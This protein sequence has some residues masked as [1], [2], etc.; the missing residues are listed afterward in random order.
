[1]KHKKST[2]TGSEQGRCSEWKKNRFL[3]LMLVP[4]LIVL[5]FNNY[6]PM[7]GIV[8]A[9]EKINFK[10]FAFFGEWVGLSNLKA[11]FKSTY[12][13]VILKNTLLYNLAF[14][15]L[16]LVIALFFAISLN[17]LRS[18]YGR[19][20]YQTIMFLPYFMSWAVMTGIV[21]AFLNHTNGLMNSAVL[22]A[23]G[24]N[25]IKWYSSPKYWPFILTFI[26][27]WKGAGYGSVMYLA[28]I[29][30]IDT[31]IF[32]A[33]AIDGAGKWTQIKSIT[34]PLLRPM[35]IILTLMNIGKIFNTDIG[36]FY[37]APQL[38]LNGILTKAVSTMD[39]YVYTN[40]ISGNSVSSI[41]YA[42][43]AAFFQSIVGFI[44]VVLTNWIVK[45]IDEDYAL[46]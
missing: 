34:L 35:V 14:I 31:S 15:V 13:P 18:Q 26:N 16:G 41:N 1:M 33:A 19:K 17:E 46:F 25:P 5:F 3:F 44:L 30:N 23:F 36:L 45:K 42:A 43:A 22:P 9:F 12:A 6:L 20:V 39:T 7:A 27:I 38:G 21:T 10:K 32:D 8:M 29:N 28:S 37:T 4:G 11:F 2:G 40:L 24:K